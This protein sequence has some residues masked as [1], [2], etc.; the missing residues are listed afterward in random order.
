[1]KKFLLQL[2]IYERRPENLEMQTIFYKYYA[3]WESL[4]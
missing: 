1:M 3:N 4:F 2:G